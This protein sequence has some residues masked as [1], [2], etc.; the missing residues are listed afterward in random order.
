MLWLK[1]LQLDLQ[2]DFTIRIII[3]TIRIKKLI[4]LETD[5]HLTIRIKIKY[6]I[7]IIIFT[8]RILIIRFTIR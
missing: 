4:Q 2:L 1:Y 5:E 6:I 3:T 7:R 8:I